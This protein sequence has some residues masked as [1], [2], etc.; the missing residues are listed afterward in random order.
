MAAPTVIS[1]TVRTNLGPLTTA[2][3][4]Y[5]CTEVIQRCSDCDNGWAAQTCIHGTVTDNQACWPPRA[6]NLPATTGALLGWGVYSP[7][8]VCPGGYTSTVG[9]TYGGSSNFAFEYPLA[10]GETA[11]GCCPEGGFAPIIDKNGD[12]TCVQF[13]PTTSFLVGSC[14]NNGP[15]YTTFAVGGTLKSKQYN[16]FSVSAPFLQLVYQ[17]SDSKTTTKT[18]T[19]KR[20]TTSSKGKASPTAQSN[21]SKPGKGKKTSSKLSVGA[22]AG[23]VI[24]AVFGAILV[25]TIAFCLWRAKRRRQADVSDP[26]S[27]PIESESKSFAEVDGAK[28]PQE[29]DDDGPP[30]GMVAVNPNHPAELPIP[31]PQDRL[32]APRDAK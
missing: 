30:P 12:Q 15:S 10:A 16:S 24:A 25:A 17:S 8:I 9:A 5:S 31:P 3:W 19:T 26:D 21:S 22:T 23:I 1:G 11:I 32:E 4:T 14:D 20:S 6:T 29:R 27:Q 28:T 7:G 18:T 13:K 2:T